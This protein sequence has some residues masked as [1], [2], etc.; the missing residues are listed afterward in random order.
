MPPLHSKVYFCCLLPG[1]F[2]TAVLLA[3]LLT[4]QKHLHAFIEND[5]PGL[6]QR[7]QTS[8]PKRIS[9]V[10][11]SGHFTRPRLS[12]SIRWGIQ[13]LLQRGQICFSF[14]LSLHSFQSLLHFLHTVVCFWALQV[15]HQY[16][17]ASSDTSGIAVLQSGHTGSLSFSSSSTASTTGSLS[18]SSSSTALTPQKHLQRV[19][20]N[21]SCLCSS[22]YAQCN[23]EK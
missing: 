14:C 22:Q 5:D 11:H 1:R 15:K 9:V 8:V 19:I 13:C 12:F 18:F 20:G 21:R 10:S 23:V 4:L 7:A 16:L 6:K 17:L 2:S 3:A